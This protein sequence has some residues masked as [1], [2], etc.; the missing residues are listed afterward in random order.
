MYD[1]SIQ[2]PQDT[3]PSLQQLQT[4]IKRSGKRNKDK[5]AERKLPD[6]KTDKRDPTVCFFKITVLKYKRVA[7][8]LNHSPCAVIGDNLF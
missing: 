2:C 4:L 6:Y 5:P 8:V 7:I 3:A 1:K